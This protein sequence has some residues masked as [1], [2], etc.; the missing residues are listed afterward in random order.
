MAEQSEIPGDKVDFYRSLRRKIQT[1]LAGRGAG[2]K[3]ADY[4]LVA[5]DLFHL[6]CRLTVDPRVS[7]QSKAILASAIA[8]FVSPIDLIPEGLVGPVG[9]VDDIAV[10]ALA[11]HRVINDG[12]GEAAREHWA[13]DGDLIGLLQEIL[14]V[15]DEMVGTGAWMKIRGRFMDP[16]PVERDS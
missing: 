2:F 13:G 1:F 6:M 16:P 7:V 10:A 14:K 3:Y 15:A 8:Y 12:G 11:L 5:P 9:Y 4:L